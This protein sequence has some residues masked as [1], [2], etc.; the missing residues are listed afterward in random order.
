MSSDDQSEKEVRYICQSYSNHS[1][2]CPLCMEP[3]ELDDINF[4]P[5]KCEYQVGKYFSILFDYRFIFRF[6]DFVGIVF[7]PMKMDFVRHV[8]NSIL[9]IRST[10]NR[11]RQKSKF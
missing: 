3:F 11:C 10:L 1:F 7:E 2:Q 9:K 8:D 5:C 6:V 4:Y